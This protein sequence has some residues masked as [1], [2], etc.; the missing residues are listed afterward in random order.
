MAALEDVWGPKDE[1][2]YQK[3]RHEV[4]ANLESAIVTQKRHILLDDQCMNFGMALH[5]LKMGFRI[6]RVGWN[7]P[8]QFLE[9]QVPDEHSKMTLPYVY[10]TTVTGDRVPWLASQTDLLMEDWKIIRP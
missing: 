5:L 8:D 3:R 4:E 7:G 10:I 2:S 9:L 1:D 6:T